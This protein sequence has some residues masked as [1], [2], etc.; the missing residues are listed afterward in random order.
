MIIDILDIINTVC[1]V[2]NII[3]LVMVK[4]II[5]NVVDVF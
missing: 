5:I 1:L 4:D 3:F 2:V